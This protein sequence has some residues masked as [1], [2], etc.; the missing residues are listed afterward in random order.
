LLATDCAIE[1]GGFSLAL[2]RVLLAKL[3]FEFGLILRH[4]REWN[5]LLPSLGDSRAD[6]H[7]ALNPNGIPSI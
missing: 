3:F 7:R 5:Y 6:F 1:Q 2:A 4:F